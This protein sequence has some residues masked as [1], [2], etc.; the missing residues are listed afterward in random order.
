MKKPFLLVLMF[1]VCSFVY[2]G[3]AKETLWN[4][5]RS[6]D[7]ETIKKLVTAGVDV[8]AKTKYNA[9]ALAYS[10]DKGHVDIV[11]YLLEHGAEVNTTDNFYDFT[12]LGWSGFNEHVEIVGLLLDVRCVHGA[13][14]V[15]VFGINS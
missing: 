4:A 11:R 12:P 5:A 13:L 1:F 6:G 3:D 8:N 2:A 15:L 14:P 9:T 7:L 10:C